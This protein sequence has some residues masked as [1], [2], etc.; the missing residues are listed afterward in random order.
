MRPPRI[1]MI[2][3]HGEQSL[4][5]RC[6]Y[7]QQPIQTLGSRGPDEPLRNPSRHGYLNR[8]PNDSDGFG[9][10][11]GIEASHKVP[12]V[13][14]DQKANRFC[15]PG[16]RPGRLPRLLPHPLGVRVR[17][18]LSQMQAAAAAFDE[19]EDVQPLEPDGIDGEEVYRDEPP[20]L[21]AQELSPRHTPALARG[22]ESFLPENLLD[23]G[24][25]YDDPYALQLADD[26]ATWNCRPSPSSLFERVRQPELDESLASD[27]DTLG[28][29]INSSQ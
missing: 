27:A 17:H 2:N 18:A 6:V 12:I 25:R 8:R 19:E 23:G 9:L 24:R 4:Q 22:T 7:D 26:A 10:E 29:L 16:K 21:R 13:V 20:R 15:M 11:H 28:L 5:M 14:A 3:E 1:V